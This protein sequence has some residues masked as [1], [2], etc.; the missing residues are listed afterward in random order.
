MVQTRTAEIRIVYLDCVTNIVF[1]C[2]CCAKS[3]STNSKD[4]F[5][6][7]QFLFSAII[8]GHDRRIFE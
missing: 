8:I 7:M 4:S 3:P 5:Q 1:L 6:Y 2:R